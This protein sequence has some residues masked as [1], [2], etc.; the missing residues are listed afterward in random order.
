MNNPKALGSATVAV[1][2]VLSVI[3][4]EAISA[5]DVVLGGADGKAIKD[6]SGNESAYVIGTALE[7]AASGDLCLVDLNLQFTQKL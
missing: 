5:G 4:G 1:S 3:T 6:T 7:S 2:G